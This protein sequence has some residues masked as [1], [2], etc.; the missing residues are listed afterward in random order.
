[1]HDSYRFWSNVLLLKIDINTVQINKSLKLC[2][3]SFYEHCLA[4]RPLAILLNA[5]V[6]TL[7]AGPSLIAV[8]TQPL[9]P[10]ECV[11]CEVKDGLGAPPISVNKGQRSHCTK[12]DS[13]CLDM[14]CSLG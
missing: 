12:Q 2:V 6:C 14:R 11:C 9:Y 7:C 5:I 13:T 8:V 3:E 4:D 10:I 1:M